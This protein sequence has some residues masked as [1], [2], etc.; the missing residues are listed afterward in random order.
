VYGR[1]HCGFRLFAEL[2]RTGLNRTSL[3][4]VDYV[5]LLGVTFDEHLNF[6]EHI[7]NVCS[8]SYFHIRAFRHIRPFRDLETSKTCAIVGSRLDYVNSILTGI[9]SWNIDRLQ[10]VQHSLARLII[11]STTNTTSALNSL[12]WIPI[13]QRINFKLTTLVTVHSTTLTLNTYHLYYILIRHRVSFALPSS[14]SS[15]DFVSTLFDMLTLLFGIPYLIIS[16]LST[17]MLS[18]HPI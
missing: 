11:R 17:H 8:K 13:Q 3:S 6:D 14:I 18:S 5:K 12:H 16:D 9:S 10:C 15:P 4:L 7:S 2:H 1:H